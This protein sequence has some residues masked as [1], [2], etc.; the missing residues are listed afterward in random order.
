MV[1]LPEGVTIN[2]SVGAGPRRLH[3]GP[4]R[5]ARRRPRPPGAGCPNDSKIGD[6]TRPEPA[7][8]EGAIEGSIFLAAPHENPFG[9]LL[10]LYLVAKSTRTR[11]PG[12][13]RRASSTPDPGTAASPP[14]STTC[15]SCPTP[16]STS[17]SAKASAAR[18]R[19]PPPAAPTRPRSTSPP[20]ATPAV[21][22]PQSLARSRSRRRRR[23][24]L[25]AGARRPSPPGRAAAS[26]NSQRRLLHALLPAPDAHR[27]R[28]GDHLLLGRAC[29]PGLLGKIAGIPYCPEAGDRGGAST[30]AGVGRARP[31]RPA[32]RPARSATPTP[33]TGVGS[34]LAYAPGNLYLA[35]PYHGSAALGR[36][37]RLGQGRALRPRTS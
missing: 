19:R 37:D 28:T 6:F 21:V 36:R 26:L 7:R 23:R 24:P 15:R 33:A 17:T 31:P 29:P 20:G 2:P 35:G 3:A 8:L 12:Q 10:A 9:T 11:H 30:D 14:P 18:W 4:V 34:A 32:R 1:T 25:P 16:T 27:R 13:G 22:Q 5:G